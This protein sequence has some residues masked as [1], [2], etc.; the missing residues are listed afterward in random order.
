[1]SLL[2]KGIAVLRDGSI[3]RLV[4]PYKRFGAGM[5]RVRGI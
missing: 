5:P 4:K 3:V 2:R 1:M